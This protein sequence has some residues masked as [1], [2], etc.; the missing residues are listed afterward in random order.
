M[1]KTVLF[2]IG[3]FR[4]QSFHH[5]LAKVAETAL[6]R[7]G[8]SVRY[9]EYQ[10]VPHFSQDIETPVLPAVQAVRDEIQAA[11]AIWLFSPVYNHSMPGILKNLLDWVSR[12]LDL[13]NPKGHSA[14]HQKVT[15]VSSVAHDGHEPL[16][17]ECMKVL[18]FIRTKP[19]GEFT[20]AFVNDEAWETNDLII[21]DETVTKLE[22]QAAAVLEAID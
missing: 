1:S 4:K 17:E 3:S 10:E 2:V 22:E 16:F 11:D 5:Q 6:V 14:I 9:L 20:G 13:S 7:Q 8:V 18:K 12:A 15:T 19:V 21:S